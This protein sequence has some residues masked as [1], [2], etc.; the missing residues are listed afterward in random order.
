[1]RKFLAAVFLAG[2]TVVVAQAQDLQISATRQKLDETKERPGG[3]FTITTK[4]I[5]YKATVLNR[6]F[7]TISD[8]EVKYMIFYEVPHPGSDE[9]PS[10]E[11]HKGVAK[12]VSIEGNRSATFNTTPIKLSSETLDGGWTYGTGASNKTKDRVTG[13]WFRAYA[14]GKMV[15]EYINPS[16]I[17][18]KN[19][20]KE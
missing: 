11:I 4:E 2:L 16:T 7:K 20:W 19:D 14:G 13:V 6:T 17:S 9:R 8:I 3:P 15:G 18:K 5:V 12:L 10:D 1:M